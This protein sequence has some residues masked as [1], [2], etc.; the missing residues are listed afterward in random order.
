M[1]PSSPVMAMSGTWRH[2]PLGLMAA[3]AFEASHAARPMLTDDARVVDPGHCQV[4]SWTVRQP[5]SRELWALPACSGGPGTEWALGGQ[6]SRFDAPPKSSFTGIGQYKRIVRDLSPGAVGMG[7][8]V[9]SVFD[10]SGAL[11]YFYLPVSWMSRSESSLIHLNLGRGSS[12][13]R[14]LKDRTW[15]LGL[16]HQI[17]DSI[18]LIAERY[19][20]SASQ[21]QTQA[22]LR[23]WVI[24]GQLQ[25]DATIG[26]Q[27]GATMRTGLTSLG[28]RWIFPRP[29]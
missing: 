26:Q 22:G 9:G 12:A 16:E 2:L 11:P 1:K 23:W 7:V 4:E 5:S 3:C 15:G 29:F 25:L 24:P 21:W 6:R 10:E 19:S 28:L 8:A 17:A 14:R 20:P 27:H 13:E 18:W